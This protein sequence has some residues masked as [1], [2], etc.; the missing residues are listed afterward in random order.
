MFSPYKDVNIA[1]QPGTHVLQSRVTGTL[2][3]LVGAD[4]LIAR[5][6]PGLHAITLAFATGTCSNERWGKLTGPQFAHANIPA[7]D[8]AG[9][10]YIVSTGGGNGGTFT[11]A[12]PRAFIGFIRRYLAPRLL[13]IDFDIESG[14]SA[15]QVHALVADAAV[16]AKRYPRLRFTFTLATFAG[17]DGSH[18]GLNPLGAM[19]V[20]TIQASPLRHYV[21]NLMVMDYDKPGR[22]ECVVAHGACAM[23]ASA[24]QAVRNLQ[25]TY[26]IPASKIALTPMLGNNDTP[27]QYFT[28]ADLDTV[29]H[30]AR[31][32]HLAGVH[33]WSLDRDT[34]C[35][36]A[37][38]HAAPATAGNAPSTCN[39]EPGVTPLAYTRRALRDL[40]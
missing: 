7:L 2:L 3:P 29:M 12:T 16:A 39:T 20:K 14:Q 13:G 15:A 26:S 8:A 4:G 31:S 33:F 10:G 23:G 6:L 18:N 35:S 9:L 19:V 38:L 27:E 36:S 1:M 34:P 32:R 28:L 40:R 37:T 24:L 25:H 21:I 30:Y 17:D 22:H 11:C 5:D